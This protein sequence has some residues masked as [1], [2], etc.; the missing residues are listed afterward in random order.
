MP[1]RYEWAV[2]I[3]LRVTRVSDQI[4][5]HMPIMPCCQAVNIFTSL[6]SLCT[7]FHQVCQL[8]LSYYVFL[9]SPNAQ[10]PSLFT[11]NCFLS[12]Y[13]FPL[14]LVGEARVWSNDDHMVTLEWRVYYTPSSNKFIVEEVLSLVDVATLRCDTQATSI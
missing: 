7:F 5:V 14:L 1:C 4:C 8:S 13:L 12:M 6:F 10:K 11:Y 9:S 2:N 3:R